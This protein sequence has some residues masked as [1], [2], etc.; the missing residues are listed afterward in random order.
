MQ[1]DTYT[2]WGKSHTSENFENIP[3]LVV[4]T[5]D[6]VTDCGH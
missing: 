4:H 6:S 1:S 5:F 3:Y 2:N